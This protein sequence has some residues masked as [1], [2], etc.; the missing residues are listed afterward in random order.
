MRC[1]FILVALAACEHTAPFRSEDNGAGGPLIPGPIAQIT[2]SPGQDVIPAWLPD[3]SAFIYT[4][5]RRDRVDRDRCFAFVPDDGGSISRYVCRTSAADDSI[6][7]FEE[8]AIQG[9]SIAYVRTSTERFLPGIGPDRQELVVAAFADPNAARLLQRLPFTTPWGVT[10]DG[11]SYIGW[12]GT[13]RL[14]MVGDS[15]RYPRPCSNCAA[16]TVRTG[17]EI[18]TMDFSAGGA[19]Q[20]SIVPGTSGA[21]SVSPGASGDTIYFTVAGDSRIHRYA[22]SSGRGDFPHDFGS[23]R[24]VRDVR[25]ANGVL[26]AVV[27]GHLDDGG[28]LH[29]VLLANGADSLIGFPLGGP[30]L[31]FQRPSLSPDAKTV[32]VQGRGLVIT[33][34]IDPVTGGVI[35]F[36]TTGAPGR[37]IWRVELP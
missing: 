17:I 24:A 28:D 32:V 10:Y 22:L 7:V 3:G 8:A 15:V 25:V 36:D 31:W 30:A 20:L 4:A 14:V 9:D 35:A 26:V 23:G 5:E 6:N 16:D 29:V 33:P 12:L 11:V 37:D 27:D 21:T 19:A 13:N 18:V 1:A 2:F 34:I